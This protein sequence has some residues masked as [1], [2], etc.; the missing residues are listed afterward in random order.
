MPRQLIHRSRRGRTRMDD[1]EEYLSGRTLY[2]DDFTPAQIRDW[3]ADEQEGYATLG[4][5]DDRF[6]EG[7]VA[8][9]GT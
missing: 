7:I 8:C 1:I 6:R 5:A 9:L 3:F 2:G 4:A